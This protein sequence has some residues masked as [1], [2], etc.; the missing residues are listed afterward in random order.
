[1]ISINDI[2]KLDIN[3]LDKKVF[4]I[5]QIIQNESNENENVKSEHAEKY[6]QLSEMYEENTI[7][8]EDIL[9]PIWYSTNI[10]DSIQY[11][12][13]QG[14][15]NCETYK[16]IPYDKS[17]IK[18]KKLLF[19][20]LTGK[21]IG[22]KYILNVP[23]IKQIYNYILEKWRG[24]ILDDNTNGLIGDND[25]IINNEEKYMCVDNPCQN[26]F[27][28]NEIINAYG[29]N[30]GTRDSEHYID[31]F[32]TIELFH[33]IKDLGIEEEL[34]CV[35]MGYFESNILSRDTYLPAELAMPYKCAINKNYMYFDGLEVK[36]L[37]LVK[38]RK[39]TGG[40][41][42]KTK[43]KTKIKNKTKKH[44]KRYFNT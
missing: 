16:Y 20:D 29:Y 11:C 21:K 6:K 36:D 43:I 40:K 39:L 42:I 24:T 18:G 25:V 17:L 8:D 23:L 7:K 9:E 13:R 28:I 19:L 27:S 1:M 37:R 5:N 38:K 22:D 35:F 26:T 34:N 44:I 32:F 4:L 41:K 30:D 14:K 12:N 10:H 3:S 31:K 2:L 33:I 15:I